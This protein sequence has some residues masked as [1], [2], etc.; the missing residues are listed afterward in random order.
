MTSFLIEIFD[1]KVIQAYHLCNDGIK[2][3]NILTEYFTKI[4]F[5]T[6]I[7]KNG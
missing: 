3:V 4:N 6:L 2:V 1:V 7:Q 5:F